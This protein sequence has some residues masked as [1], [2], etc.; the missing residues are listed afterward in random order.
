MIKEITLGKLIMNP[1]MVQKIYLKQ[2]LKLTGS[3]INAMK[4]ID[5]CA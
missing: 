4:E 2:D 5:N 1:N 3:K